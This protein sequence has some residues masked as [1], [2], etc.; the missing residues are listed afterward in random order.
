M[1][2]WMRND[3]KAAWVG[4]EVGRCVLP[5]QGCPTGSRST[6]CSYVRDSGRGMDY[7]PLMTK[8]TQNRNKQSQSLDWSYSLHSQRRKRDNWK[9]IHGEQYLKDWAEIKGKMDKDTWNKSTES[10]KKMGERAVWIHNKRCVTTAL[11]LWDFTGSKNM[12]KK[13]TDGKLRCI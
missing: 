3:S 10:W 1:L 5:C 7:C 2:C 6:V 12:F 13:M 11:I 4:C 9:N 8:Q